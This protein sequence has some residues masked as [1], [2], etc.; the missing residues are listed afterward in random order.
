MSTSCLRVHG[1]QEITVTASVNM[2][3]LIQFNH[4]RFFF[5][6]HKVLSEYILVTASTL[7]LRLTFYGKKLQ[8][9][10]WRRQ[11]TYF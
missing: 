2:L 9:R 5:V 10:Y 6:N 11:V 4:I 8:V 7:T 1:T 3:L